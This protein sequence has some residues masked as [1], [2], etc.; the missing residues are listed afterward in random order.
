MPWWVWKCNNKQRVLSAA[1]CPRDHHLSRLRGLRLSSPASPVALAHTLHS[2]AQPSTCLAAKGCENVL[3]SRGARVRSGGSVLPP[4]CWLPGCRGLSVR[5][6][7]GQQELWRQ[8]LCV[9]GSVSTGHRAPQVGSWRAELPLPTGHKGALGSIQLGGSA[10]NPWRVIVAR[11]WPPGFP[12]Q[13]CS[14]CSLS[15]CTPED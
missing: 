2:W 8:R 4:S 15:P 5:G 6:L 7:E 9:L 1:H 12:S 3:V 14:C 10:A 13:G 11:T